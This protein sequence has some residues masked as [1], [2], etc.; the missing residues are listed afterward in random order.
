MNPSRTRRALDRYSVLFGIAM[1]AAV[2]GNPIS[3]VLSSLA[4]A[5]P[6]TMGTG[7]A[8]I[9]LVL[10]GFLATARALGPVAVSAADASWRLLS[11]LPRASVLGR[12]AR[13]LATVAVVAGIA[14]G[15]ALLA[16]LGA[17]DHLTWRLLTAVAIGVSLTVGGLAV[18]VLAQAEQQWNSWLNVTLVVLVLL[19][20]VS[21]GGQ[22]RRVLATVA[23]APPSAGTIVAAVAAT[24][25][26]LLVRQAWSAIT[27]MPARLILAA[28]TRTGNAATAAVSL[29]PGSL[30]WIAEDNHWRS[31]TLKSK[32]WPRLPAPLALAWQDWRR[33]AARPARLGLMAGSVVL[34]TLFAQA[35][36]GRV[37]VLAGA[38][39]VAAMGVSGARRDAG[40]PAMAHLLGVN[41]RTALAARAL[42]P[43]MLSTLWLGAALLL[44]SAAGALPGG[45]WWL[46][47]P[48]V[49]PALAAAALRIARRSPVDHAM[50][51][52][53]TPGGAVPTGPLFWA[54]TG[55]DL[56][57]VGCA[58]FVLALVTEPATLTAALVAQ[59][60]LGA[61]TLGGYLARAR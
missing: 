52:I 45:P 56:A 4:E 42:L 61:A 50:P 46:F 35:G 49:A 1:L 32:P 59:A 24:A 22:G 11:P 21:A 40:N 57:L 34:P 2:L 38:L 18:A 44:L 13:L 30:T 36:A 53:D 12:T 43:A 37:A 8:L 48:A 6:A 51:V 31:R 23:A 54:M 3:S 27:R 5:D 17:P 26:A 19:A 58:P 16:V 9:T 39:A 47:A 33:L 55:V 14:L 29:D 7:V 20:A 41:R 60:A 15:V 28:S 25:A 10:A